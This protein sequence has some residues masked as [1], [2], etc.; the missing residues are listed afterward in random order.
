[1]STELDSIYEEEGRIITLFGQERLVPSRVFGIG[2]VVYILYV[3]DLSLNACSWYDLF[4]M[5]YFHCAMFS[6]LAATTQTRSLS[7]ETQVMDKGK[8]PIWQIMFIKPK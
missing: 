1:V 6:R 2:A 5:A 3:Y 7:S 8:E 4:S